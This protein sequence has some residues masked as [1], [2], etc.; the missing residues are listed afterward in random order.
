MDNF[1]I[2][3]VTSKEQAKKFLTMAVDLYR[4]DPYW[5]RPWDHDIEAVFDPAK[6]KLFEQGEAARWILTESS[7]SGTSRIVGR[8][9]A[10]YNRESAAAETQLTGGCGFFECIDNQEA[11][12]MLFDTAQ[13]WLAERGMEA[14]DG[15]INFGDRMMWWGVLV[16]GFEMPIYGMNYNYPYYGALFENYG[17][18][19]FFNQHS[20]LRPLDNSVSL[21]PALVERAE[22][23]FE[24]P[25]YLY[26]CID[27]RNMVKVAEDFMTIYNSAWAKFPGV[28]PLTREH[29]MQQM[30]M[31]KPIIDPEIIFFAYYKGEPIAF[32]LM[33]PDINAIVRKLNGRFGLWQKLRFVYDLKVRKTP[34]RISGL[35]FGVAAEHQGRGVE[36]GLIRL[37]EKYTEQKRADHCERYKTLDM[38]WVGDFNPIMMRMCE[39]YIRAVRNKRHVTYRYLFDRGKAFERAPRL[40]KS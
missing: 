19:N 18:Q 33:V 1:A 31:M 14:M 21:A 34:T 27:K 10:F 39:T 9:A 32:F 13:T 35:T 36:A 11:A 38:A 29:A 20:Y 12:N 23:L 6:N 7:A 2:T 15:S 25:D 5:V 40:G 3:Q 30:Q 22:R 17:F 4:G 24:N 16:E 28:K 37:F 8:I 26:T